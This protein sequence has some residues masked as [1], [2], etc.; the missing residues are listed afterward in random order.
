MA[1]LNLP[2]IKRALDNLVCDV[3]GKKPI[4]I[5]IIQNKIEYPSQCC[6]KFDEKIRKRYE[7]EVDKQ[8]SGK[9][10]K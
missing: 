7:A 4:G 5:R 10:P 8:I 1:G 3:H 9:F 6:P 2:I